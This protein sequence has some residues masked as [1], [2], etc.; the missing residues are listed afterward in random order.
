MA[1]F[2]TDQLKISCEEVMLTTQKHSMVAQALLPTII[3]L[4]IIFICIGKIL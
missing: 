1:A 2:Y 4:Q 3:S